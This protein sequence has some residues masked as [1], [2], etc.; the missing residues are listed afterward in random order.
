MTIGDSGVHDDHRLTPSPGDKRILNCPSTLDPTATH[1][2]WKHGSALFL[3]GTQA[4][5]RQDQHESAP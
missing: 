4:T 1:P 2:T 3:A 5:A